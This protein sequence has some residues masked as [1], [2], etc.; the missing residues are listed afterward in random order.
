MTQTFKNFECIIVDN[1]SDDN[2]VSEINQFLNSEE[3]KSDPF[4]VDFRINEQKITKLENWNNPLKFATGKYIAVLEGD[5]CFLPE[6]LEKA[7]SILIND[8]TIGLLATNSINKKLPWEGKK[9]ADE[10]YKIQYS[11]RYS[12]AP[13]TMIFVRK[14][15]GKTYRYNTKDYSYCPEIELYMQILF[16]GY[17]VYNQMSSTI[18]RD[19][20]N[21]PKPHNWLQIADRFTF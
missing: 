9:N 3:Y 16:D 11:L 5:D 15:N 10:C 19:I 1:K 21:T 7:Y 6:H 8:P 12:P 4:V 2:T 18:S 14:H 13:S 20:E 17:N